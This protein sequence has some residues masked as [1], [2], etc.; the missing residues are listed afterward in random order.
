M[1]YRKND[2]QLRYSAFLKANYK[3][4]EST[5]LSFMGTGYTRERKTFINWKDLNNALI[6]D[7]SDLRRINKF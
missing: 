7:D 5:S 6:P 3:F 1:S 2:D 4:S